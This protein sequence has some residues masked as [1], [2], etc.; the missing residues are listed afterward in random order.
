MYET[1]TEVFFYEHMGQRKKEG[2]KQAAAAASTR[3][4]IDKVQ[5]W[6]WL[7]EVMTTGEPTPCHPACCQGSKSTASV[8]DPT[9]RIRETGRPRDPPTATDCRRLLKR[10]PSC[11]LGFRSSPVLPEKERKSAIGQN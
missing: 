4:R 7:H 2:T 3:G 5:H 6:R 10:G 9:A 1:S 8:G 11:C